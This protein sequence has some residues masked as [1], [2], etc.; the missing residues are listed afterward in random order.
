[1]RISYDLA[2][3]LRNFWD[4][5]FA[6]R[7]EK[8]LL[9]QNRWLRSEVERLSQLSL[10]PAAKPEYIRAEAPQAVLRPK[11]E[12]EMSWAELQAHH[13]EHMYD[14]PEAPHGDA[15]RTEEKD[16]RAD[17]GTKPDGRPQAAA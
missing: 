3:W 12:S 14:P 5:L 11:L 2:G 4:T 9:E 10:A 13:R 17:S 16:V 1:M 8:H 7:F 15:I 6:T